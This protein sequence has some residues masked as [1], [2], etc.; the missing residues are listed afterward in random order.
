MGG[1]R[2][3]PEYRVVKL[4]LTGTLQIRDHR[5]GCRIR[6]LKGLL[7][8]KDIMDSRPGTLLSREVIPHRKAM[9]NSLATPLPKDSIRLSSSRTDSQATLHQDSSGHRSRF[10]ELT[11]DSNH[12]SSLTAHLQASMH[13]PVVSHRLRSTQVPQHRQA[14]DTLTMRDTCLQPT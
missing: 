5:T 6:H 9:A 3:L 1:R 4:D 8:V 11:L 2:D 12:H 10:M 7:R 13:I 14:P